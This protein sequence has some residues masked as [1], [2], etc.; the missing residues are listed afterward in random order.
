MSVQA[1]ASVPLRGRASECAVLDELL[2]AVRAGQSGALVLRGDAGIGKTALMD[3]AAAGGDGSRVVRSVGVES[4]MELTFAALH[5]LCLQLLDGLVRL[6]PPQRDALGTAFGMSSG[7]PPDRFLVGLAVLSLLSD[8]AE[9]QPLICLVDDAQW[10]DRSSAQV[11]SFVARRLQA[12]SVLILF[13]DRDQDEPAELAGLPELRLEGLSAADARQLLSSSSLGPLDEQVL[14]R[15]VA[16]TRGNPLAL[17]ELPR[18]VSSASLAGGFALPEALPL[19]SR[20]EV[21]FRR[22]VHRLPD[23]TQRLLLVGA[24][25][26]IGDPTLLWRAAAELGISMDAAAPAEAAELIAIATRVTFRHPLLRSSIYGAAS[27]EDRRSVHRAL[28]EATDPETDPD[29]RAWHRAHAA[30]APDEDVAAALEQ[31]ADRAQARGGFAAAAAFLER[32]AALTP[33]SARRA[34]RA[35]AAAEVKHE[36]GAFDAAERLVLA[37]ESGPLDELQRA[38][39]ER[40]R[41][42]IASAV[43]R[44]GDAPPLLLSAAKRLESLDGRL[45]RETYL[46]ALSAAV[47]AGRRDTLLEVARALL[48]ATP[49]EPQRAAELLLTGWARLIIEGY[50]AGADLMKRALSEFRTERLSGEEEI[51]WLWFAC[52]VA[53]ANWDDES[54]HALS[55]RYVQLA[56]DAGALT[57]LPHALEMLA[58]S[59]ADAGEFAA[60]EALTLEADVIIEAIGSQPLGHISLLL[61]AW[62]DPEEVAH[63]RIDAFI[64]DAR[65]KGQETSINYAEYAAA[66]LY[67]GL[68]RYRAALDAAERSRDHHPAGGFGGVLSELVEAAIRSDEPELAEAVRAEL[69]QRTRF[70]GTDWGLGIQAR[71][72]ALLSQGHVA[73]AL[74]TEAIARLGRTRVRT[75]LARAHLVYG[76]WLRR[77]N[78]RVDAREQL[79]SAH[80]LYSA[81]G[82]GAFAER[83]RRELLATGET[84]R[85]RT[86]ETRDLL[87]AQEAQIAR[88]AAD[89]HTNPEI[90]AQLFLSPRTVEWHLRKVFTKLGIS[91]RRELRGALPHTGRAA[92]APQPA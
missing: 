52:R 1:D 92:R 26:P 90:G 56:R 55:A 71:A 76:E 83:A 54:A 23:E 88:L 9:A 61:A 62:R 35:L 91:S 59:R 6:P 12:E 87:T 29:R 47:S 25:E 39:A 85:R 31:S 41:A 48:A 44:G 22:Q 60:A 2:T 43:N 17:L 38:R 28:A 69:S 21:S 84:V 70:G 36:A 77:E 66:V 65:D 10:L 58:Q 89:G 27:P 20:I 73:E 53:L 42:Q 8:A 79:R 4:E 74:Y 57:A 81:M 30:R 16:E 78:R 24:A 49:L 5:Q 51:R 18:G 34:G 33:E 75:E 82:A 45:A 68:R 15:I 63:D 50:P 37:A 13:A 19:A 40:L 64:Q 11:L 3:Y 72:D 67:N 46:E 32:S 14:D 7:P 86:D 80:E